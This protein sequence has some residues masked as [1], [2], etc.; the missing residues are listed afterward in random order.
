M[1]EGFQ[2]FVALLSGS[3]A[4]LRQTKNI[5]GFTTGGIQMA[6]V[7]LTE[8]YGGATVFLDRKYSLAQQAI[9]DL[10]DAA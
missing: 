7:I 2:R 3:R 5:W 4:K 8:L 1:V 10:A 9:R 6:R